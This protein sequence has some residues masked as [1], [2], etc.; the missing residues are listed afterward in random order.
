MKAS[1]GLLAILAGEPVLGI[2]AFVWSSEWAAMFWKRSVSVGLEETVFSKKKEILPQKSQ[3]RVRLRS[4]FCIW[5]SI[6][7][8]AA[9]NKEKSDGS[10]IC[11]YDGMF[12]EGKCQICIGVEGQ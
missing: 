8:G 5:L 9:R 12:L 10:R 7:H 11:T 1:I 3:A 4:V 2:V 6:P